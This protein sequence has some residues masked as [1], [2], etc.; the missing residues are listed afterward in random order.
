MRLSKFLIASSKEVSTFAMGLDL[1][2]SHYGR[3]RGQV[4]K[5]VKE[6]LGPGVDDQEPMRWKH[7]RWKISELKNFEEFA[8][9]FARLIFTT[10]PYEVHF[11]PA[12]SLASSLFHIDFAPQASD[13][14]LLLSS[15]MHHD[16]KSWSYRWSQK[17][18]KQVCVA[19]GCCGL[20][21]FT[22]ELLLP[23]SLVL[24]SHWPRLGCVPQGWSQ[25]SWWSARKMCWVCDNM[26]VPEASLP[27]LAT[28]PSS[29]QFSTHTPFPPQLFLCHPPRWHPSLPFSFFSRMILGEVAKHQARKEFYSN[30]F[31]IG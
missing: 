11:L 25:V 22:A 23:C 21:F 12:Q 9:Q 5:T 28:P 31:S 6:P 27:L 26:F 1:G 19:A 20:L 16:V 7:S 15:K 13:S 8:G 18:H 17:H 30:H 29:A 10:L 2:V 3:G 14:S 24:W 4:A